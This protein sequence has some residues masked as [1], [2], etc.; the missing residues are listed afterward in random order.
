MLPGHADKLNKQQKQDARGK[1]IRRYACTSIRPMPCLDMWRS[2]NA[3]VIKNAQ[4][5]T[6]RLAA[7]MFGRRVTMITKN[8]ASRHGADDVNAKKTPQR[9]GDVPS[10]TLEELASSHRNFIRCRL[11]VCSKVYLSGMPKCVSHCEAQASA[12]L[13]SCWASPRAVLSH[14]ANTQ[15]DVT[16]IRCWQSE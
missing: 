13:R 16:Y 6:C 9:M 2:T 3:T 11:Q 15:A 12:A 14:A 7:Q 10:A 8:K 1:T 4:Q 5:G